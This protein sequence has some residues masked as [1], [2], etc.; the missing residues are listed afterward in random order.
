MTLH[1]FNPE[2][3]IALASHLS[4]FTAPH[5]A[6]Q[7][8]HDLGW[9]PA[10]WASDGDV[11]LAD[12]PTV[13]QESWRRFR[14]NSHLA[15]HCPQVVFA[16]RRQIGN[17][18]V[19]SVQPWGWDSALKA[20]LLR[21]GIDE[22]LLPDDDT[23]EHIRDCSSRQL[24]ARLLPRLRLP[25]TTGEAFVCHS[26]DEVAHLLGR[27][28][29]IVVKAPWSSSGRGLRFIDL[30]RN[31]LAQQARWQSN[32]IAMQGAVTVEP[33]YHKVKDFGMEF[34]L[35]GDGHARLLG[36]SLFHTKNGAYTGNIIATEEAKR[37]MLGHYL[38]MSLIDR[39]AE[40]IVS[41]TAQELK[42]YEG[43]FGADMM[44]VANEDGQGFLLHPCVELNLRRTMGHAAID[45]TR[46]CNPD[47][48]CELQRVMRVDYGP[49][50]QLKLGKP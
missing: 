15:G 13:S 40:A 34:W 8:R 20:M 25:G 43:P 23:L 27:F 39:V 19:T 11:V 14:S 41:H 42:G 36:L 47:G 22:R 37:D 35:D 48:D 9:M 28:Q 2:H 3:D 26:P 44:V 7:L 31:S 17:M 32:T 18:P 12:D 49:N 24:S 4:N 45:L 38:P 50:Y 29:Q 21:A 5:A 1:I 33:Y 6:R 30:Q 46:L 16:N 10:L